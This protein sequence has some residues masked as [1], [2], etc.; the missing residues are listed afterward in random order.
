MDSS[1]PLI[2][3]NEERRGAKIPNHGSLLLHLGCGLEAPDDW[4]NVDGSLQPVFARL[5]RL[6]RALVA[7]KIYPR[8]QADIPWPANVMHADLRKP[9]PFPPDRFAAIYSS[10]TFEHLYREQA[11]ALA[12]E[13]HRVLRPHGICRIVVPDLAAAIQRYRQRVSGSQR[14]RAADQLMDEILLQPRAPGSGLLSIYHRIMN[15]HQHKWM[16]DGESLAELLRE[17]G[18]ADLMI[19]RSRDGELPGLLSIEKPSRID[20]GAGVAV[21]GKKRV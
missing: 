11:V 20:D 6:K 17:C 9:L 13:C 2:N 19:Y 14:E 8:S 1:P 5:P 7:A 16:Y 4:L 15:V 3:C 18:F 21:E 12:R 10:H